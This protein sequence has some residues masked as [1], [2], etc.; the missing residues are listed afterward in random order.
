MKTVKVFCRGVSPLLMDRMTEETLES[1]DTGVRQQISKDRPAQEKAAEK[2][3]RDQKG[4]I[5]LPAEMLFSALVGAGRNVKLG[6]KAVSTA[7]ST[8]LPD[9][10]S[11]QDAYLPLQNIPANANGEEKN[12]W[13]VDLRRGV[14]YNGKTPTA[15]AI[16]RPKF[17][18]WEFTVTVEY[19]EKKVRDDT[20]KTLFENAG[21]TQGLG[22]FRPNKKGMFGRFTVVKMEEVQQT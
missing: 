14:G 1:L 8:T 9:L 13:V 15:V 5:A 6:K 21:S 3:Y 22:S 19:D 16:T 12:F 20:I 10:M 2:I 7:M 11:I 17:P 18:E 4:R